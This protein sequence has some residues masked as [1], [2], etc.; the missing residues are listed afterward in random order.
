MT[1]RNL[2]IKDTN[3]GLY[4][5]PLAFIGPYASIIVGRGSSK[6]FKKNIPCWSKKKFLAGP[7]T[8]HAGGVVFDIKHCLINSMGYQFSTLSQS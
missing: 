4:F 3:F 1:I 5:A 2:Y 6:I 8:T 7:N